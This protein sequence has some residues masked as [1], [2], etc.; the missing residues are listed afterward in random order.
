MHQPKK[1]PP[2][3]TL[4]LSEAIQTSFH[5]WC[6]SH[7]CPMPT[8]HCLIMPPPLLQVT[9]LLQPRPCYRCPRWRPH[10]LHYLGSHHTTHILVTPLLLRLMEVKKT[11]YTDS[12]SPSS[13]IRQKIIWVARGNVAYK[14]MTRDLWWDLILLHP[15][16]SPLCCMFI[17]LWN[18][19]DSVCCHLN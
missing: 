5:S 18:V 1:N 3:S 7:N 4:S 15:P 2:Q 6:G 10:R 17:W 11:H 9:R 16:T 14:H 13:R 8:H 19:W 12:D